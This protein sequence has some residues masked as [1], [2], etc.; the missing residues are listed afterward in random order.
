[1]N[2]FDT[3]VNYIATPKAYMMDALDHLR[4]QGH[5]IEER[6]LRHGTPL[7]W[8]HIT[9]HGSYHVNLSEPQRQNGRRPLR[10][11]TELPAGDRSEEGED[12]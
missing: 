7:L 11:R 2:V 12:A 9:F 3:V 10:M 4:K 8:E 6:D 5:P 1:M